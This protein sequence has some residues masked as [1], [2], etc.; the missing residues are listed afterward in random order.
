MRALFDADPSTDFVF[1]ARKPGR[2]FHKKLF[3]GLLSRRAKTKKE[4]RRRNENKKPKRELCSAESCGGFQ[5]T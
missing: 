4:A 2:R 1:E 5:P 3:R